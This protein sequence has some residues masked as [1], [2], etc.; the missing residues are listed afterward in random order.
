[1]NKASSVWFLEWRTSLAIWFGKIHCP[2][3]GAHGLVSELEL[4][5]TAEELVLAWDDVVPGNAQGTIG[6]QP[7]KQSGMNVQVFVVSGDVG[8]PAEVEDSQ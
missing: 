3:R 5:E 4:P 1:M 8:T 2:A 6:A 7:E